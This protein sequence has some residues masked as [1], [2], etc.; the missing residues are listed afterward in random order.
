MCFKPGAYFQPKVKKPAFPD[1]F[2]S[3]TAGGSLWTAT[4]FSFF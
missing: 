1:F 4:G 3:P 2:S